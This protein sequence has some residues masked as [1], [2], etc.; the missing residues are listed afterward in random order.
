MTEVT[1]RT[2]SSPT[3]AL[4]RRITRGNDV[5]KREGEIIETGRAWMAGKVPSNEYFSKVARSATVH[6][7]LDLLRALLTAVGR[8]FNSDGR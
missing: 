8:L 5:P 7:V 6:P 2:S 4:H 1:H 3:V